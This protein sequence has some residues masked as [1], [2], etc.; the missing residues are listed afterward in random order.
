MKFKSIA[1]MNVCLTHQKRS[2][3]Y[4]GLEQ[5]GVASEEA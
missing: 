5:D 1:K 4:I 2:F 3:R